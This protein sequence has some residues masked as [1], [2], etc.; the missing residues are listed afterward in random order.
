MKNL[1]RRFFLKGAGACLAL[2]FLPSLKGQTKNN[3]TSNPKRMVFIDVALGFEPG[4]FFPKDSGKNYTLSPTLEP[5]KNFKDKFTV[6][7]NIEHIGM[8]GGHR[9]QHALLSGVLVN[10]AAKFPERNISA[11]IKATELVGVKTRY[12]SLCMAF[13]SGDNRLSWS[14]SGNALPMIE[15]PNEIF[16]MLF[17]DD[18]LSVKNQQKKSLDESKSVLDAVLLQ[19]NQLTQNLN[20][21]DKAKMDEYLTSVRETEQ[22]LHLQKAWIDLPKPKV[23]AFDPI[24]G[25]IYA[26][27]EEAYQVYYDLILLALKTDSTRIISVVFPP[28]GSVL[29]LP[30]ISTGYHLLS[31]H[32]KD[33]ERLTQLH[34]IEKFHMEQLA[35]FMKKLEDTK[36]GAG[37]LL[38][39]TSIFMGCSMG[40]ASSHSNRQLPA[41]LAGGNYK[42]AGHM[43]MEKLTQLSNLYVTMLQNFGM[44]IE[45]F[46]PSN[47]RIE[48]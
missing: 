4:N 10:D 32:G 45:K 36:E 33:P 8:N 35:I 11:D 15:T 48:I 21:E 44:K 24:K 31:H 20:A 37:N 13:G 38:E 26:N 22:K 30:E 28:T 25:N 3:N 6:F 39:N 41:L 42:H 43:K 12:S 19:A 2:P 40:N 47:G 29:K 34:L 23:K 17:V 14:K 16:K 18:P 27:I 9:A 1:D 5:L 46:G 7:S